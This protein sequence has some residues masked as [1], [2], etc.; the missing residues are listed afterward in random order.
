MKSHILRGLI[1]TAGMTLAAGSA[2]AEIN[3]KSPYFKREE[4]IP[5]RDGAKLYTQ[6]YIPVD[7]AASRPILLLRTPYALGNYGPGKMREAIGPSAEF[8]GQNYVVAYQEVRGKNQSEGAFLHHPPYL[9]KKTRGQVDESSDAYDTIDWLVKNIPHN[10]GRVGMWGISAAGFTTYMGLLDPHPALRAASPQGGPGVEF[11]GDDYR[12]YGAFRPMIAFSWTWSNGLAGVTR[13]GFD[14]GTPDGYQFFL[15]L[16]PMANVNHKYFKGDNAAWN[17]YI[18]HPDYD[19]FW[20]D[21]DVSRYIHSSKVPVLTVIGWFDQDD[22]YGPWKIFKQLEQSPSRTHNFLAVGPW[23]HGDWR[24]ISGERLGDMEFGS[25]TSEHYQKRIELA[26]F[27]YFLK[28]EGAPPSRITT[29][30]TGQN[31]WHELAQWPPHGTA[32]RLYL[33]PRGKLSFDPPRETEAFDEYVS[34]PAKPVP[35]SEE[36]RTTHGLEWIVAD[37][38]FASRRPDVLVYRSEPLDA[39]VTIAGS[40]MANV[41]FSTTGTDADVIVKLIDVYPGNT[42]DPTP[43]PRDVRMGGYEMLLAGEVFRARYLKSFS[44]PQPL[45]SGAVNALS[46]DLLDKF[47]TF[48]KGHR[49]MIQI[50]STWFPIVDR[51]PQKFVPNIAFAAEDDF[52][53]ANIRVHRSSTHATNVEINVVPGSR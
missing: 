34:D 19:Q 44:A 46:F 42:P 28:G 11:L 45:E 16:G 53:K 37:Q 14:Y 30:E 22:Y 18:D 7:A 26:F 20:L 27:N 39:D 8:A 24:K 33:H 35:W 43:N 4:M 23:A 29:F 32:R 12:H 13:G 15:E 50:Q 31:R 49:I 2:V 5:M 51:N 9:P 21:R 25:K 41:Y 40:I 48:K 6:I 38:R 47:H 3:A 17:E 10:N 1:L 52:Q 36:N